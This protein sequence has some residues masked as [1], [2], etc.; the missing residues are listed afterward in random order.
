MFS[1]PWDKQIIKLTNRKIVP[2]YN[3][4]QSSDQQGRY[5][6]R[7]LEFREQ[8]RRWQCPTYFLTNFEILCSQTDG[9]T[10]IP[11]D[12]HWYNFSFLTF[13]FLSIFHFFSLFSFFH[14]TD[15]RTDIVTKPK[16]VIHVNLSILKL[17]K[18]GLSCAKLRIR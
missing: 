7:F 9:P 16:L 5:K 12:Q 18:L 4:M 14:L 6:Q 2:S 13:S 11:T 3:R 10:N 1:L 8:T 15:G 17:D